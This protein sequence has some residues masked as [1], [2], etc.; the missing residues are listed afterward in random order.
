[1]IQSGVNGSKKLD[2]G[3]VGIRVNNNIGYDF[4]TWKGLRQGNPVSPILL[5]IVTNML[6]I[7]IAR[8]K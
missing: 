3:S 2:K 4:Q 7:L 1:L 5:N 6:A 8:A